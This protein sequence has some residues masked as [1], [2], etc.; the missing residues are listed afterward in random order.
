MSQGGTSTDVSRY[1]GKYDHVSEASIAGRVIRAP[2]L[3]IATVAAGG[4]SI[5]H[6]RNGLLAVGPE[7]SFTPLSLIQY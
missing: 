7:A 6:A 3:N 1:D 5:L 2:M 4:G